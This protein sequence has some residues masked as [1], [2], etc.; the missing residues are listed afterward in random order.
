[1]LSSGPSGEGVSCCLDCREA[2]T[3]RQN[4]TAAGMAAASKWLIGKGNKG[5]KTKQQACLTDKACEIKRL[6]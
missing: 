6:R 5:V 1:L 2:F 4:K 3:A